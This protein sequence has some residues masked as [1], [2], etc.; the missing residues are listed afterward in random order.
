MLVA[1]LGAFAACGG[2]SQSDGTSRG[3]AGGAGISG[4]ASAGSASAGKSG[5]TAGDGT[6]PGGTSGTGG[7][8]TE[9]CQPGDCGP[10]LGLP[11][12]TCED[13]TMGGP[14]GRCLRRAGGSCGWEINDCPPA[15][16]SGGASQ[17]GQSST[18]GASS[19]GASSAGAASEGG[20]PACGGCAEGTEVCVYQAG[21]PGPARFT[22]A[23]QN[24]CGAAG[25]CACI[26][27]QGQ[28]MPDRM[29][30]P[31]GYCVCDNGLD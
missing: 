19:A 17:G 29:G 24:V 16:Q 2:N 31:P 30:S 14:T 13:G 27:G 23:T 8:S 10:Q 6:T 28:C 9:A 26:V 7:S 15:S 12:W 22:C 21:G 18:A 3:G 5:G 20:A 1:V 25:A 11:N 4:S